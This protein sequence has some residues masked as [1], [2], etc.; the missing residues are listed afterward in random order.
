MK[1]VLSRVIPLLVVLTIG[2]LAFNYLNNVSQ[3][4][5][6]S[7]TASGTVEAHR[8]EARP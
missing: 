7:L 6:A 2:G 3:E 5:N 1:K 8:M 4:E